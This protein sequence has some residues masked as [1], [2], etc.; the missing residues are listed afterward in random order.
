M[1]EYAQYACCCAAALVLTLIALYIR[2][3][4]ERVRRWAVRAAR[5]DWE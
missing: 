5:M 1:S 3:A 4:P 2:G